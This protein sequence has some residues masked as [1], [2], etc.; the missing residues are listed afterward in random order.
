MAK[1][2]NSLKDWTGLGDKSQADGVDA[3]DAMSAPQGEL[4][5]ETEDPWKDLAQ[6]ARERTPSAPRGALFRE[7]VGR[8]LAAKKRDPN[9][10]DD[11]ARLALCARDQMDT[12]V[13][14]SDEEW[15]ALTA[16]EK[17]WVDALGADALEAVCEA[18][19]SGLSKQWARFLAPDGHALLEDEED[20]ASREVFWLAE[21]CARKLGES[22]VLRK[23][24]ADLAKEC[25]DAWV[26]APDEDFCA[27]IPDLLF[28]EACRGGSWPSCM[29]DASGR[30]SGP[31]AFRAMLG[32][33]VCAHAWAESEAEDSDGEGPGEEFLRRE[34]LESLES[35]AR[36]IGG[37][38][39][40]EIE[41]ERIAAWLRQSAGMD[42]TEALLGAIPVR[43]EEGIEGRVASSLAFCWLAEGFCLERPDLA[44]ARDER[45]CTLVGRLNEAMVLPAGGQADD[46]G[47]TDQWSRQRSLESLCSMLE[48]C[49]DPMALVP[50]QDPAM[51]A[52]DPMVKARVEKMSLEAAAG[53]A[54]ACSPLS[55]ASL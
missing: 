45:G 11:A 15:E 26:D 3:S 48:A 14:C 18:S 9:L 24:L 33:E 4:V 35:C 32:L 34:S 7:F 51:A 13:K 23:D 6:K 38:L 49:G 22:G 36:G 29:L 19:L 30:P 1:L 54:V 42:G 52:C 17:L 43:C 20:C 41:A 5:D 8:M 46:Y 40:K 31:G 10:E 50:L 21:R 39:G 27:Y 55:A 37:R 25:L 47:W 16:K 12:D 28:L 44:R 53:R 2:W